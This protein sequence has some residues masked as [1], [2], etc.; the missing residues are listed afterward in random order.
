[1]PWQGRLPQ[2]GRGTELEDEDEQ[3]SPWAA[4]LCVLGHG[5]GLHRVDLP[6]SSLGGKKREDPR[7]TANVKND[8]EE[9]GAGRTRHR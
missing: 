9:E 8:L 4:D 2:A 7:A 1:M 6:R 3:G 5:A